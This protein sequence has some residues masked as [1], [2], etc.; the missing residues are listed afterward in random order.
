MGILFTT[1]NTSRTDLGEEEVAFAYI[2]EEEE[3]GARVTVRRRGG[4][5]LDG[6]GVGWG[7]KPSEVVG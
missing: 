2:V 1:G 6:G 5:G 7:V 3:E 4:D